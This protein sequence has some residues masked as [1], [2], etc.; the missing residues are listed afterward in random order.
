MKARGLLVEAI[1]ARVRPAIREIGWSEF[2]RRSGVERS[3]LYKIFGANGSQTP[4]V[5]TLEKVLACLGEQLV[6]APLH[7]GRLR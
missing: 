5:S 6:V 1:V 3:L 2:S 4:T 7:I